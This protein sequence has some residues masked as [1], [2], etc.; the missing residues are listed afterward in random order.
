LKDESGKVLETKELTI[1]KEY[2]AIEESVN[3]D[4]IKLD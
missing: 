2:I 3:K 4:S 1:E